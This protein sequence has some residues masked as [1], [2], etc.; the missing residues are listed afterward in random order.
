MQ[1]RATVH[2]QCR[3]A[4]LYA[5][6]HQT[7]HCA[8]HCILFPPQDPARSPITRRP[9]GQR[10]P[11]LRTTWGARQWRRQPRA[12][13]AAAARRRLKSTSQ[14]TSSQPSLVPPS[15]CSR[16]CRC[17]GGE[18]AAGSTLLL[19]GGGLHGVWRLCSTHAHALPATCA[20]HWHLANIAAAACLP[21]CHANCCTGG[22]P[23]RS[24][25]LPMRA[26]RFLP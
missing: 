11:W 15:S 5:A 18:G 20:L 26:H 3:A 19:V 6:D 17:D 24:L 25:R 7:V 21:G 12:A 14:L 16:Q 1:W 9:R 8:P 13:R 22:K 10:A 2:V 4:G 23:G